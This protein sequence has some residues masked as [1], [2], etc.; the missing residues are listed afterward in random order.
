ML[1]DHRDFRRLWFTASLEGSTLAYSAGESMNSC[2]CAG[3]FGGS[4]QTV[5]Q[6]VITFPPAKT[7]S[8]ITSNPRSWQRC[9]SVA[10][11]NY[12]PHRQTEKRTP[13]IFKNY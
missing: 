3:Q 12:D 7:F 2:G 11:R 10:I 1:M 5:R 9:G 6:P 4:V 8:R 13:G